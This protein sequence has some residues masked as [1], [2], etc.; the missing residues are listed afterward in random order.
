[1]VRGAGPNST[2]IYLTNT[3][4]C[5][6]LN[7]GICMTPPGPQGN[8]A[9][10]VLP[11][12]GNQQCLWTGGYTQGTTT[13]TVN[14][15][16]GAPPLN[17]PIILDQAND[18]S[19]TG[20]IYICDSATAGCT[21]ENPGNYDGRVIGGVTHSQQQ[22][23]YVTGVTGSGTGPYTLTISP[24]VYFNNIRSGQSP[25]I[26]WSSATTGFVQND[27]IENITIDHSQ[28][29]GI[30][31]FTIG[32]SGG[33]GYALGDLV[34]V[35]GISGSTLNV[36]GIGAGGAVTSLGVWNS[37][38]YATVA[39]N[40]PTS[41]LSGS[42][43]GLTIDVTSISAINT[44]VAM[45]ACYQCW[46][47]NMRSLYA[48][49]DHV[50]IT[51]GLQDV[52][53]DSYMYQASAHGTESYAVDLE[54]SSQILI[55][56]NIF[57][58]TTNPVIFGQ[59]AGSVVGYNY[60][61]DNI[62]G[63]GVYAQTAY[64]GHNAGNA[65]NLWEGNNFLGIWE[66]ASWGASTAQTYFRNMLPGWQSG[67]TQ[68]TVPLVMRPWGRAYNAMGN[69]M[70]QPSYHTTYESYAT[71]SS[72]GVNGG[73][74]ANQ[75][76]YSLGWTGRGG[77]GACASPPVCDPAV[78]PTLIRWGNY[79]TVTAGVKWDS[80]EAAPAAV[81]YVNANF[82]AGYFGLL[83][84]TLPASLY[85]KAKPSWWP[86]G[87][88]WPPIGPDVSTGNLG[89]CTGTF[90]GA[91]ATLAGQCTGGTLTTAWASHANSIPAQDCYLNVMGG[92]PDGSGS[93]LAFDAAACY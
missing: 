73:N 80:T 11:P 69:V 85:Y 38:A 60:S 1:V 89:I 32:N 64:S 47:K 34:S 9:A 65:M 56:N 83:A 2:Y 90:A 28:A 13:I 87:K 42:G 75:G 22:F 81:P 88:A 24:G 46:V 74:G 3:V 76:I 12:S 44:P 19:D 78:R 70:G 31:T 48:G 33:S 61:V 8:Q 10:A 21:V 57:Q 17:V 58:Q 93:V 59:A 20:G 54:G 25:G 66:D 23:V 27:G 30:G 5:N 84:H 72:G 7:L 41:A 91:Q 55:E 45:F 4:S 39:N 36:A 40:I 16:P 6:G 43:L 37:G 14:S 63:A 79:D 68:E 50:Y 92:P 49:R 62:F 15:C 71:S 18:T 29:N 67:K 35:S 52:V 86:A 53:W 82:T 77:D 26:W 51:L